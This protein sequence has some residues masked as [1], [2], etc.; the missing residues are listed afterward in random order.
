ML[1]IY[2]YKR[3][4]LFRGALLASG[5]GLDLLNLRSHW[6]VF[7]ALVEMYMNPSA[8]S[9]RLNLFKIYDFTVIKTQDGPTPAPRKN[10]RNAAYL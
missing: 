7:L 8:T 3:Y 10:I 1:K 6:I 4:L 5:R 9:L 2:H